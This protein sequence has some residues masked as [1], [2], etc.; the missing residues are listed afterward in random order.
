MP[1][2][3]SSHYEENLR[4][5]GRMNLFDNSFMILCFKD[6]PEFAEHILRII[7]YNPKLKV[8][9]VKVQ[10]YFANLRGHSSQLDV[11]AV[12]E[13]GRFMNIEIQRDNNYAVPQRARFHS[14]LLDA[15][16]LDK[17]R[18]YDELR[19]S[20]VIFITKRDY[21]GDKLPI[22]HVSRMIEETNTK[23]KDGSHIIYVNGANRDRTPLGK[24]M[25]DF[26]CTKPES[27]YYNLVADRINLF[28]NTKKG[29]KIMCSILD[30]VRAEGHKE[31]LNNTIKAISLLKSGKYA[32]EDIASMSGLSLDEVKAL[33][34]S[35]S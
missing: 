21:W 10:D 31:C 5:I 27:M 24:L 28:K 19:D 33:Q 34:A 20:Y 25:H 17:N 32:L 2:E 6:C 35:L 11:V 7:L 30:E 9:E 23:F 13:N 14:S 8:A 26:A 18:P 22:Y 1:S 29:R 15:S 12:D 4:K 16:S 3:R